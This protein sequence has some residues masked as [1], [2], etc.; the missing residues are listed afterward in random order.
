MRGSFFHSVFG[1]QRK[2]CVG[3]IRPDL[4]Q[5]GDDSLFWES[6]FSTP[7]PPQSLVEQLGWRIVASVPLNFRGILWDFAIP[8]TEVDLC[9]AFDD[10]SQVKSPFE[11]Q[12]TKDLA[13]TFPSHHFFTYPG[14]G[15]KALL[16]VLSAYSV[17]DDEVGYCQGFSFIAGIILLQVSDA[18]VAFGLFVRIMHHFGL[19]SSY[20]PGMEGLH[21]RLFQ[22]DRLIE[23]FLPTLY[24]RFQQLGIHPLLFASQWILTLYA[25]NFP[26]ELTFSIFDAVFVNGPTVIF[27]VALALL[28]KNEET[29]LRLPFE[30][31][32]EFLKGKLHYL[33]YEQSAQLLTDAFQIKVDE[34][35]L[36]SWSLE[37]ATNEALQE[38]GNF[39]NSELACRYRKVCIENEQL[40]A[41]NESLRNEIRSHRR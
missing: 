19:R 37:F 39:R 21:L 7:K 5:P 3:A 14:A 28:G 20:L 29:L 17:F 41:E 9:A 27:R 12:I 23:K 24:A 11:K 10:L 15:T 1:A 8:A 16:E 13:R 34:Q 33:Y 4:A 36:T 25:Y 38:L 22:L 32:L 40:Q 18:K 30:E 26:F 2:S 6:F 31:A 35:E